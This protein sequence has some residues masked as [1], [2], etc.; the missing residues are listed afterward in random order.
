[1]TGGKPRTLPSNGSGHLPGAAERDA[2]GLAADATG[3]ARAVAEEVAATDQIAGAADALSRQ[4]VQ[5]SRALSEQ[6]GAVRQ[7]TDVAGRM[8]LQTEQ[9]GRALAE[10][11]RAIKDVA[12]GATDASRQIKL[13]Q[14]ANREHATISVDLLS[15]IGEIRRVTEQNLAGAHEAHGS[16]RD[17][18]SQATA[19]R[20]AAGGAAK[21][22]ARAH[23]R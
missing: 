17:L 5:L 7:M 19:L 22:R 23:G 11:S 9:A 8:R 4:S 13:I 6:S 3:T 15:Q 20:T 2:D 12:A 16:A 1:L 21:P 10:Q 14:R 18:V